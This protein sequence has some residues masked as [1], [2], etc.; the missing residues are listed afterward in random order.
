[1]YYLE[2]RISHYPEPVRKATPCCMASRTLD[3]HFNT[4]RG[5]L[6][7]VYSKLR[8]RTLECHHFKVPPGPLEC[9][10]ACYM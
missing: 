7:Y 4:R 8:R 10:G 2:P 5:T 6:E 3:P 9:R 1:M